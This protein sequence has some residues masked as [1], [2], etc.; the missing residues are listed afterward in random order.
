[1]GQRHALAAALLLAACSAKKA[2]KVKATKPPNEYST[3]NTTIAASPW[4]RKGAVFEEIGPG[5]FALFGGKVKDPRANNGRA[6][7]AGDAWLLTVRRLAAGGAEWTPLAGSEM[8]RAPPSPISRW[9][10]GGAGVNGALYMF[11]GGSEEGHQVP[12]ERQEEVR[13]RQRRLGLLGANEELDLPGRRR[14]RAPDSGGGGPAGVPGERLRAARHRPGRGLPR[15]RR[16][17]AGALPPRRRLRRAAGR[18]GVALRR[19]RMRRRVDG[20]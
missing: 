12:K 19:G 13:A 8:V 2:S 4:R 5:R 9:K 11:A 14:G 15:D 7:Y 17:A 18:P 16:G 6:A 1:M 3:K 20:T 10:A